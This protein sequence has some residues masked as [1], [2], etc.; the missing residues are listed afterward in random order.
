MSTVT[1]KFQALLTFLLLGIQAS[2][3]AVFFSSADALPQNVTYDFIIAGGGTG[4]SVVASRLAANPKWKI[5]VIE[6]GISNEGFW[7]VAVAGYWMQLHHSSVDWNFTTVPQTGLNGRSLYYSRAKVLGGCSSHNG[8]IYTRGSI[9]D[10][11]RYARITGND[12]LNWNNILP[13]LMKEENWQAGEEDLTGH[14]DPAFHG[15]NGQLFVSAPYTSHPF[16]DQLRKSGDELSDEFP[17]DLDWN[18]G[19]PVGSVT[20]YVTRIL[21]TTAGGNDFRVIE[22]AAD[23]DSAKTQITAKKEVL[24]GGGIFGSPQ[25]LLNSG[26]GNRTEL[27][28][29]GVKPLID[30]PSVGK[31]LSDQVAARTLWT[32]SLPTTNY[33]LAAALEQWNTSGTGPLGQ[34]FQLNQLS[35]FRLPDDAPP[36]KDEGYLDPSGGKTS[37]HIEFLYAQIDA[38]DPTTGSNNT[39]LQAYV[40]NLH[41]ISR[42]SVTLTSSNPFD[43]PAIDPALLVEPL[44][45]LIL[46]EAIRSI[47][48]FFTAPAFQGSILE[49]ISPPAN[50][51]SDEDLEAFLRN[52]GNS[53]LHSVGSASM[54]P[55]GASWGVVDPDF[56]VKGTKGLR[57]IDASVI[58]LTPSAHTQATVYGFAEIA[59]QEIIMDWH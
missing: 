13:L 11:N 6:A 3:G 30:N 16:N 19:T 4:G 10:W 44:D 47:R 41:P 45:M 43:Y 51:T 25:I 35:F 50:V 8:E 23:A 33:D 38:A 14:Y 5:L 22:F 15:T 9:D 46:R 39:V 27:E 32:T 29:I 24:L 57:I 18:D 20:N 28:A 52:G 48:R 1:I 53:W 56:K 36:F 49:N 7:P 58:P 42:G 54:T 59:S 17:F 55:R 12:G 34:S 37:P 31:N 2:L 26:I 40:A 21:P